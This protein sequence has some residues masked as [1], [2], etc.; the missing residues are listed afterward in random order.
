[1]EK[2]PSETRMAARETNDPWNEIDRMFDDMR[3]RLYGSFGIAPWCLAGVPAFDA[4]LPR[5]RAAPFDITDVGP[6]YRVTAELPGVPKEALEVIVH[7]QRVEIR[8][9]S[10][11]AK[12]EVERGEV[13]H[14]ERTYRGF[15][16]SFELPEPVVAKDAKAKLENGLLDLELPKEHPTPE[17]GEIKVPVQ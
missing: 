1:M 6:A 12:E 9:E 2:S 14:R 4:E 8:G 15:Y 16:R 7:G 13:L 5:R 3:K 11:E 10:A 17:P